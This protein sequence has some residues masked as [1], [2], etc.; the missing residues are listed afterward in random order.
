MKRYKVVA[1]TREVGPGYA[2]MRENPA[3]EWVEYE[4]VCNVKKTKEFCTGVCTSRE[5]YNIF[6]EY[7]KECPNCPVDAFLDYYSLGEEN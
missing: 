3:G 7:G 2:E 4:D 6:Q 1:R 5:E